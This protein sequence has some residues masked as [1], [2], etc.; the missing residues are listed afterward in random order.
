[1]GVCA[2]EVHTPIF[3]ITISQH[4]YLTI[5][6]RNKCSKQLLTNTC[7]TDYNVVS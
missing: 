4:K 5:N 3:F 1:M 7:S 2:V 6:K